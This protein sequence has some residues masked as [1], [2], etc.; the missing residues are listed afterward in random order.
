MLLYSDDVDALDQFEELLTTL[1]SGGGTSRDFAVYYLKFAKAS[2]IA[3]TLS[4]IFG[5]GAS[6]GGGGGGLLG[7]IAGAALGDA[8][9][10]LVGG[11]LGLGGGG[12]SGVG[13]LDI[14]PD[15]R[16][17]ALVVKGKA[18][19]LE[20]LEQ[21]L[22]ILDQPNS[23][24]DVQVDAR[25][26]LIPVRNTS[27]QYVQTIVQ[28]VY[29]DRMKSGS[30]GE[31]RQPSPEDIIRA[32]RGGG[33]GRD[34]GN[35]QKEQEE[36]QKMALG[37]DTRSNSLVVRAPDPLFEEVK[38]LVEMIDSA[39]LANTTKTEIITLKQS[40][41][42]A[43][44]KALAAMFGSSIQ[45]NATAATAATTAG[46]GTASSSGGSDQAGS[47]ADAARQ[48]QRQVEFFQRMQQ[49]RGGGGAGRGGGGRGG[50]GGGDYRRRTRW[51]R[52]WRSRRRRWWPRRRWRT[53][54][55][56]RSHALGLLAINGERCVQARLREE[57]RKTR[58]TRR[59]R[60]LIGR[61]FKIRGVNGVA[62]ERQG[63]Y[64]SRLSLDV[65]RP[66]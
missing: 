10:D 37:I 23:P 33:G 46:G 6:A 54:R 2:S 34:S 27:A 60:D 53:R 41:S 25:P 56:L 62:V 14:V 12:S 36:A 1:A 40:N 63:V 29:R 8:G 39:Q 50:R 44:Q 11:L 4:E 64:L 17:N 28:T 61:A 9:G 43:V 65:I 47:Q 26:R 42:E 51:R 15:D 13:A 31:A 24:E 49:G 20:T 38:V 19:D 30:G 7:D 57:P 5:G 3:G 48:M 32:L 22:R 58:K 52:R 21:L 55:E 35:A 16:L 45:T 59:A 66:S 18:A